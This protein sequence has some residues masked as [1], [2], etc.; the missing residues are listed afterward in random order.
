[1]F[2]PS[3]VK[4]KTPSRLKSIVSRFSFTASQFSTNKVTPSSDRTAVMIMS[5]APTPSLAEST[6]K[7]LVC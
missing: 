7:S 1:V 6:T 4:S 5:H 3:Q 2:V